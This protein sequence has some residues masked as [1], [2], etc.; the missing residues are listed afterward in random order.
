MFLPPGMGK[1]SSALQALCEVRALFPKARM[2]VLAPLSVCVTT[3]LQEPRKWTQFAHL[4][5]GVAHGPNKAEILRDTKY[6]IVVLNYDGLL[7]AAKELAKGHAFLI[8]LADELTKLKHTT[9]QRFKA[10]KPILPSFAYRWGLTGTPAANGL[11]DLFGQIYVLDN[12]QRLGKYITHYRLKYF[13]QQTWDQYRWYIRPHDAERLTKQLE[14]LAMY[15]DPA[16]YLQLP[17]QI[18]V[19]LPVALPSSAASVYQ[20]L[21]KDFIVQLENETVT[22]ANAGILTSKLRQCTGGGI[23][24]SPTVWTE[25]HTAKLDQLEDLVEEMAGEPLIVAYQFEHEFERLKQKFPYALVLRGGMSRSS[26]IDTV[27]AWNSGLAPILL[28]QPTSAALGLNLQFG[29]SALCWFSLT[30]NLEEYIQLIAR[31][32]R[33]GQTK[34]VRNYI[35]AATGTIDELIYDVLT[36]KKSTQDTLFQRLKSMS[37]KRNTL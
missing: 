13:Y 1:T 12:G 7:W 21:E 29:G 23:Y 22:A 31:L 28:V 8:L 35:I 6:D 26:R 11:L 27:A 3:W 36:D 4:R 5:V 20:Q 2:L 32:L 24:S 19:L 16:D 37:S 34:A 17:P 10:L 25:V 14:D 15:L 18:D 9:S 33:Q 30:Y